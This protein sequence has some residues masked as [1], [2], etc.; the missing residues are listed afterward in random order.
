[1]LAS[2]DKF[3]SSEILNRAMAPF[4]K[5]IQEYDKKVNIVKDWSFFTANKQEQLVA[6]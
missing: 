6:A 3:K 4:V 5:M 1:M 2:M